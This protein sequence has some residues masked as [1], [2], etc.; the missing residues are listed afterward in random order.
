MQVMSVDRI[1]GMSCARYLIGNFVATVV[2]DLYLAKAVKLISPQAG[3]GRP[4][5]CAVRTTVGHRARSAGVVAIIK[6]FE[7]GDAK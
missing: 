1:I 5:W 4:L 6:S 7:T 3:G 2:V